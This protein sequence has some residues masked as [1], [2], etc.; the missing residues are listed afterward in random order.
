[1]DDSID[2]DFIRS[3]PSGR[4][5]SRVVCYE[6]QC[7]LRIVARGHTADRMQTLSY[8][9][10]HNDDDDDDDDSCRASTV[11]ATEEVTCAC[12]AGS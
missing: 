1:M 11:T 3:S 6:G 5:P 9:T 10:G 7:E 12:L 8:G 2:D 4:W